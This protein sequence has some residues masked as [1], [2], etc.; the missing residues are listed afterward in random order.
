MRLDAP[1][2]DMFRSR[3][4]VRVL[5]AL[6]QLPRG[7]PASAREI[8]R[9]AGVSHP[10]ASSVL[11][12]L[13]DQGLVART[14]APRIDSF[15]LRRTHAGGEKL[16]SMFDWE[17]QLRHELASFLRD[18]IRRHAP[19]V[20]GAFLF[21]SA[22]R[23]DMDPASDIDL[24]LLCPAD[25]TAHVM[26]AMDEIG[27]GVRERFGNRLSVILADAALDELQE[28]RRKGSQLW[29]QIIREGIPIIEPHEAMVRG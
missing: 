24:A 29:R 21:G 28:P 5:R 26:A 27:E 4:Y 8:A 13:A 17:S 2:D 19:A 7:L 12:S 16:I 15:E 18:E 20:T 11:A 14:R 9:R 25:A 1:L 10:T 3:S 22:A 6:Y 23:G